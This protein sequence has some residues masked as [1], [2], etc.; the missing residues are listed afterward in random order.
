MQNHALLK[1]DSY[2]VQI[3]TAKKLCQKTLTKEH[4][5]KAECFDK[6]LKA[7]KKQIK[8]TFFMIQEQKTTDIEAFNVYES[9]FGEI[10][11]SLR[12]FYMDFR[13]EKTD[14]EA[15]IT[16]ERVKE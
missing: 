15:W 2:L 7:I 13:L 11:S 9:V 12:S 14:F 6:L 16:R 3:A 1:I 8:V 5:G 4:Q 10:E